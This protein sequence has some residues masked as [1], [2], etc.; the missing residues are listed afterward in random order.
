MGSLGTGL[1]KDRDAAE[2]FTKKKTGSGGGA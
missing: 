2:R 1:L